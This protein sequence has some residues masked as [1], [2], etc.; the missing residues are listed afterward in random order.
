MRNISGDEYRRVDRTFAFIDLSG[1][2][3]F[4]DSEGDGAAL[5]VLHDFKSAVRQL[6][7]RK[8]VRIAKWLGDGA[9]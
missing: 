4:I 2:T 8:G 7:A 5:E 9:M 1:F 6:A 3:S